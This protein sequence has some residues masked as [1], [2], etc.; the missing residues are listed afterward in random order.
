MAD[1]IT[2]EVRSRNMAAIRGKDTGPETT[3]RR[4]LHANGLRFRLHRK[5]LPGKPDIVLPKYHTAIFVHGCFWHLHGC[6]NSIMPKTR[7]DWWKSK[8]EGNR[9]RDKRN[10]QHLQELGWNVITVWECQISTSRLNLLVHEIAAP[11]ALSRLRKPRQ[12]TQA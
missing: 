7:A 11:S 4:F 1:R 8:L 6:K 9:H 5:D 10:H 12:R 2:P 3:V